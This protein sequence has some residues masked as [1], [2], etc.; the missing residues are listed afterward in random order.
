MT[1]PGFT[2][3]DTAIGRCGIAWGE[4]GIVG[5]QLP[6]AREFATRARM[7]E[8]F[9]DAAEGSPPAQVQQA[10]EDIVALLHGEARDLA[11][12]QLDM[13]D[14][15]SFHQRVYEITRSITPGSTLTYGEIA[16]R[17]GAPGSARAVGQ[18][19]GRNPFAIIVPCHRVLA[20]GGKVGGFS[21]TG[22]VATKLRILSIEDTRNGQLALFEGDGT[23]G[24]DPRVAVK[25][26]H[27]SDPNLARVI[28]ACQPFSLRPDRTP[29]VFTALAESI[30]YQQLNGRAAATI[31]ARVCALFPRAHEGPNA[32]QLL[33]VSDRKL[34]AAGLSGS[35]LLSL[36]DLARRTVA[37]EIP[38]LAEVH[39]MEDEAIIERLTP[40]RGIGRWTVEMLL[41]FRLGRPDVLPVDDFGVRKGFALA[42][43]KRKLPDPKALLKHGERWRPY[44][45][46][47]SWYLWRATELDKSVFAKR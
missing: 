36:R 42:C 34:R 41:I 16:T 12:L 10:L 35:K 46:V 39:R 9:P 30:V 29:S 13:Q 44:R 17:L 47:A 20:A 2:L 28:D 45:S 8:R 24:Y 23:L 26:V 37:G 31:Y 3:F 6:E 14:V 19:L 18:A 22:G 7:L 25:H 33:R 15:P 43:R 21:A 1:V 27:V 11:D 4:R 38:T 32:E 40:V 5:V